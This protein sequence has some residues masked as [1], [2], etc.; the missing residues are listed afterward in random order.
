ME[1]KL[2]SS[3]ISTYQ[4]NVLPLRLLGGKPYSNDKIRWTCDNENVVQITSFAK[5]MRGG[6]EFTD[7]IL[8]TFLE[9][10]EATV[11]ASFG[12]KKYTCE[13]EVHERLRAESSKELRYFVGDM[14]DHTYNKHKR[15]LFCERGP[16]HWPINNY[17][18]QMK[19]CG[20]MDFAVVSDHSCVLN[21]AEFFRGYADAEDIG[22]GV[23]YFPGGESQVTIREKDR[24]G[25]EHMHG[26]EIVLLNA[27]TYPD[28]YDWDEWFR[29]LKKS[30]FAFCIFPHPQGVGGSVPGIWDF[31]LQEN[32]SK[33]FRDLFRLVETGDGGDRA[34][35]MINFYTYSVALDNGFHV[36]PTCSSDSHGSGGGWGYDRF[37]GK[38]VIMAP[39][40]SKEAFTDAILNNR[41]YATCSG[42]VKLFYSVN[43]KAA[44]T[45]LNNEGEYAFHVEASYFR[46][47]EEDT[48][49][50]RCRVISDHGKTLVELEN[51]GDV[52]DFTVSAP[53]AHWFY[54]ELIDKN[55]R[56]TWSCPVWT[57]KP[58]EKKKEKKLVPVDKK[59]VTCI[60]E[61]SGADASLVTNDDPMTPWRSEN[62]TAS[63]LFDLGNEESLSAF[64][65]YPKWLTWTELM[66]NNPENLKR[67]NLPP[68]KIKEYPSKYRLSASLDGE[69]FKPV[70]SGIFRVFGGEETIRFDKTC[71]RYLRLE[72]LETVG[73]AWQQEK[74]ADGNVVIGEITFWK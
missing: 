71:A 35:N 14:H 62:T 69:D 6:S 56:F 58:F 65:F 64:S 18:R 47:G 72:I 29:K 10:G 52:F 26:G 50:K 36:S 48:H 70:T 57:G 11:T 53:E 23:V 30:P 55:G 42:N 16:E 49:I 12:R 61:V 73:K 38:T 68:K 2:S 19:E 54:L 4:G 31:Y 1:R 74:F 44:P 27:V 43:G 60:D 9:V 3:I 66:E 46:M 25:V 8:L 59:N 22:E 33:R 7:G 40:K 45:T 41:V 51:M 28:E 34:T 20:R 37:P 21:A 13:I 17:M 67:D 32:N 39:E 15:D 63:L 5:D 24:F